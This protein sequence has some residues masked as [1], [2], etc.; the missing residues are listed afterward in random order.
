M[1]RFVIDK[2]CGQL[3][4][5]QIVFRNAAPRREDRGPVDARPDG[6]PERREAKHQNRLIRLRRDDRLIVRMGLCRPPMRAVR[7]HENIVRQLRQRAYRHIRRRNFP[8]FCRLSNAD[9]RLF[10]QCR[11]DLRL[12]RLE[13]AWEAIRRIDVRRRRDNHAR[14]LRQ[15]P[16]QREQ[17]RRL[18]A[19]ADDRRHALPDV[20]RLCQLHTPTSF[21]ILAY[22]AAR[23]SVKSLRFLLTMANF[24]VK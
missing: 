5:Q 24:P 2:R 15:L 7:L 14:R 11:R 8:L 17:Q 22:H 20:Q 19:R 23:R 1:R 3:R 12:A 21:L 4:R 16:R 18:S 9:A 6:L 10:F 13:E